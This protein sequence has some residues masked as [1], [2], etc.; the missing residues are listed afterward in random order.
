MIMIH[1]ARPG[2]LGTLV[3]CLAREHASGARAVALAGLMARL[4]TLA[5]YEWCAPPADR[6][7]AREGGV[8][9]ELRGR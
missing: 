7:P 2:D 8:Q 5:R 6:Q 9:G 4:V 1:S 3:E